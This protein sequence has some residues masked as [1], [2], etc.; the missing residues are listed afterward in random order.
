MRCS[1]AKRQLN[2]ITVCLALAPDSC[3]LSKASTTTCELLHARAQD[4]VRVRSNCCIIFGSVYSIAY[5]SN[6]CIAATCGLVGDF[7]MSLRSVVS[8]WSEKECIVTVC[9][10]FLWCWPFSC[11]GKMKTWWVKC[12]HRNWLLLFVSVFSQSYLKL[13]FSWISSWKNQ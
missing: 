13:V 7:T 3:N 9:Q 1:R 6:C 12:R 5:V 8:K 10:R 2:L 11:L 4:I